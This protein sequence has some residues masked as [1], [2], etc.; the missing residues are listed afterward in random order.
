[1]S[2]TVIYSREETDHSFSLTKNKFL[3]ISLLFVTLI[4]ACFCSIAIYYQNELNQFK[5]TALYKNDLSNNQH[6]Q[7]I[8][9]QSEEK[10]FVL[11][12]KIGNLQAQV[13]RLNALAKRVV[14]NSDLPEGEFDFDLA[15]PIGILAMPQKS[16]E[17]QFNGL[18]NNIENIDQNLKKSYKQLDQLE[19]TLNNLHLIDQLYISGRPVKGKGSWLFSPFGVR[20]DPF[21][22]HLAR[23]EGVDSAGSTGIPIIATGAGVVTES[24]KRSGYG[25]MVEIE[26]GNGLVTRYARAKSLNV[27]VADIVSKGQTIALMR[28]TGRSTG[29]HVHYEVLKNGRQINPNYYIQRKSA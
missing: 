24:G 10:L 11:A 27:S 21:T 26:H 20:T 3:V 5:E 19:I 25:L 6:V 14:E 12:N 17:L 29:A 8:K 18:L 4:I 22:G 23:H 16:S 15:L 7:L 1:M 28:S 2:I 13:N 9:A